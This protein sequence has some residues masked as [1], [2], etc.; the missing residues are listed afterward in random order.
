MNALFEDNWTF[1]HDGAPAHSDKKTNEWLDA[2]VPAFIKSGP[3]GEWPA[4]SPDLNW[5]ENL[6]GIMSAR[7][8]DPH[9]PVDKAALKRKLKRVWDEISDETLQN[10]A[11]SMPQRLRDVIN[12]KGAAIKK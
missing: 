11:D 4:K 2:N 5:I 3:R 9:P 10:C 12:G 7:V 8:A 1:L 6:F